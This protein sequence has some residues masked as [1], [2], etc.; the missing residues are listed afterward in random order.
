LIIFVIIV[1]A[2]IT[3]AVITIQHLTF[4]KWWKYNYEARRA[5]GIVTPLFISFFMVPFGVVEFLSWLVIVFCFC[6]GK[7]D[8]FGVAR[9][10]RR[11]SAQKRDKGTYRTVW[12]GAE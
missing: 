1:L 10:R 7:R 4:G 3:C 5:M 9:Q 12:R 8:L 11:N 6:G 2:L